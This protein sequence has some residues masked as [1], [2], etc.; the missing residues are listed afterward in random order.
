MSERY[1]PCKLCHGYG[2]VIDQRALSLA[3]EGE[4]FTKEPYTLECGR[5][6]GTG[7]NGDADNYR[8]D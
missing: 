4:E 1:G 3:G 8:E 6:G 5:C 7:F 2:F